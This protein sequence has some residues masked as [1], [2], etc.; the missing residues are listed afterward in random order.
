MEGKQPKRILVLGSAVIDVIIDI[1]RLPQ[2]GEDIPGIQKGM[3]VGGCA[4]NVSKILDGLQI[5]HDLCVPVGQG[6]YA[7]RIRQALQQGGHDVLIEDDRCDNGYSLSLVE[8]DGERTFISIDG[9]ETKWQDAWLAGL[10]AA[11]YDYIYASGYGF[12]D[13]NTSGDVIMRF[14]RRKKPGCRLVL[15]PGPRLLGKQFE[16]ELLQMGTI[17]E[18]NQA[19]AKAMGHADDVRQAARNLQ[20]R[21]G[22][23]VI[24][25]MGRAGTMCC[26]SDGAEIIPAVPVKAIDTIGA[27][28]SHTAGFLAALAQGKTLA[29]ACAD[30]NRVAARVVQ[31]VGCSLQ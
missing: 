1:E 18:M 25:T 13:G 17:L 2:A 16:E 12:Q 24:V 10:E 7:D 19:E 6:M 21:T 31:H 23:P 14:L 28:D 20:K 29:E 5:P 15:D 11:R 9:I 4:F 26:T 27:G 3:I 22:Q 30:A 8:K